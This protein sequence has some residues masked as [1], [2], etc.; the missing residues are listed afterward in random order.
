MAV[1]EARRKALKFS[2]VILTFNRKDAVWKTLNHNLRNA[3]R[4][5]D[6]LIHVD[7]GSDPGFAQWFE[8]A[9]K[10][11]IQ[12]R[13]KT[14]LGVSKGY[15]RGLLLATGT[16]LIMTGI[17]RLMPDGWL[18]TAAEHFEAIENTGAIAIYL[19][20]VDDHTKT[21]YIGPERE[22]HKRKVQPSLMVEARIMRRD[23]FL[24]CGF[25]REDFGLYGHEDHEWM[26]RAKRVAEKE[27]YFNYIIPGLQ[28]E[29]YHGTD[30]H[31]HMPN[32][33]T[34]HDFK[35]AQMTEESRKSLIAA[36]RAGYPYYNPYARA[37]L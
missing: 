14:N 37:E 20:P 34:Y 2:L 13:H 33:Q 7:N 15:N 32:G 25:F 22:I 3:G 21:R 29:P 28:A 18:N 26:A 5:I 4:E 17:D 1:P 16:H 36:H 12:V 31:F 6:E 8:A 9:F 11:D 23:F 27:G 19:P 35:K 24:K 30:Y 10:P